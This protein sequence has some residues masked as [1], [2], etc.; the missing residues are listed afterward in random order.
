VVGRKLSCRTPTGDRLCPGIRRPQLN[1]LLLFP[2][3]FYFYLIVS[4]LL[5]RFT[6]TYKLTGLYRA[7]WAI[8]LFTLLEAFRY[9]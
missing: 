3:G 5:L 4:N 1:K 6:W 7:N 9:Q 8:M 2:V